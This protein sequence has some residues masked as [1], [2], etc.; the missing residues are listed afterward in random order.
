MRIHNLTSKLHLSQK[1]RAR[2]PAPVSVEVWEKQMK[3]L[4]EVQRNFNPSESPEKFRFELN[5]ALD[6]EGIKPKLKLF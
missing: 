1:P 2:F 6:A 4:N 3:I 5:K